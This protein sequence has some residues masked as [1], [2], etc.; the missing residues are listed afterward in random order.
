MKAVVLMVQ[1]NG[2]PIVRHALPALKEVRAKYESQGVEFLLLNS[3]LQDKREAVAKEARNSR[4]I[5]R[6]C[7]MRRS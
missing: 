2:C 6:S 7:S 1:G 4:S 3:N 5:S